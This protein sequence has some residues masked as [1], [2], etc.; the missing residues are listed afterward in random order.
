MRFNYCLL[1]GKTGRLMEASKNWLGCEKLTSRAA[2]INMLHEE[3]SKYHKINREGVCEQEQQ[4]V[5]MNTVMLQYWAQH[6]D[7]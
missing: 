3:K 6:C 2:A 7:H 4:F 5:L 1:L